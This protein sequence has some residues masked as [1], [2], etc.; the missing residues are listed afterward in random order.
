[1]DDES[2]ESMEPM[3]FRD[4]INTSQIHT[5]YRFRRTCTH[6]SCSCYKVAACLYLKKRL[7]SV[8]LDKFSTITYWFPAVYSVFVTVFLVVYHLCIC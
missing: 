3:V 1:M 5:S 4:G 8:N 7:F 2:G 6:G